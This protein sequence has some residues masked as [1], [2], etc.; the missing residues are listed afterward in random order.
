MKKISLRRLSKK[1]KI[2]GLVLL[3]IIAVAAAAVALGLFD[4]EKEPETPPRPT[5]G[6]LTGKTVEAEVAKRPVLGVMIE[7]HPD[8]RPQTGLDAA[9]I[10]FEAVAEGG[11]TRYLAL[12]QE[13]MPKEVGSVR[14][15]RAY[16]LD[17]AMGFDASLAHV[18]GSADALALVD[19]RDAK[20]L[21]QFKFSEPYQRASRLEAPH[22]MF[23]NL[24]GLQDLQDELGHETAKFDEIP[25]SADSPSEKPTAPKVSIDFSTPEYAVEFRY[26]PESNDYVR[27]LA[28]SPDVDNA[29]KRPI[30][31]KNII[32]LKMKRP[33][34]SAIGEGEALV[35]KDGKVTTASWKQASHKERVKITDDQNNEVPLNRGDSWFVALPSTGAVRH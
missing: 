28:G 11:I 14:S 32:I 1:Q 5:Y 35:F 19:S 4:K 17:W 21:N 34:A 33:V 31:V 6:Q 23:A 12:Y 15:V 20:S 22:N 9:S 18:G 7:N 2:I 26:R 27:Y 8:A 10:V 3:A 29:T 30:T 16:Y 24:A 25:R 13:D